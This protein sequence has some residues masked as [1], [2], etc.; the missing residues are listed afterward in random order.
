MTTFRTSVVGGDSF[1][2]LRKRGVDK[3]YAAT[4]TLDAAD[5]DNNEE[6]VVVIGALTGDLTLNGAV[7]D[8]NLPGDK[9]FFMGSASGA[10]RTIT[11]GTSL[12]AQAGTLVVTSAKKFCISFMFDGT[13]WVQFGG[14]ADTV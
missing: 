9:L 2:L 10:D 5:V 13:D 11:Y 3:A 14:N 7:G 12:K 6:T 4:I 8:H 1:G